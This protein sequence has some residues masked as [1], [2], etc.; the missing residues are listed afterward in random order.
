MRN[1]YEVIKGPVVSEKSTFLA[2]SKDEK[3]KDQTPRF[4][5]EVALD[6]S[7]DEIRDS[8]EHLFNVRVR[9]VNT[10]IKHGKVK[11]T[12]KFETKRPNKKKAIV[13]LE[14]GQNIELFQATS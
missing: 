4:T 6:A 12:G 7:K 9:K 11:R 2:E 1:Y 14:A 13:E 3:G 8:I 10:M 5:F